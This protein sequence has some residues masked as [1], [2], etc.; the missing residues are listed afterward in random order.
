MKK[1]ILLFIL[2]IL[3]ISQQNGFCSNNKIQIEAAKNLT[4]K[5]HKNGLET[6]SLSAMDDNM[7]SIKHDAI[8]ENAQL[9]DGQ[10]VNLFGTILT[11]DVIAGLKKAGFNKGIFLK[12]YPFEISTK[13]YKHMQNVWENMSGGK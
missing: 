12:K 7:V 10:L 1:N 3:T 4:E 2:L 5:I 11:P 13:Y 6:V 8:N 9:A